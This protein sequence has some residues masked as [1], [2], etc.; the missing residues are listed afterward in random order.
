MLAPHKILPDGKTISA[1]LGSDSPENYPSRGIN[2]SEQGFINEIFVQLIR[3][4]PFGRVSC[5]ADWLSLRCLF[6]PQKPSW[7]L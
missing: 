1:E 6:L 3:N 5:L 2:V 7:D 4:Q